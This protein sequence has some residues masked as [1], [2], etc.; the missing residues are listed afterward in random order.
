MSITTNS[1]NNKKLP[2]KVTYNKKLFCN[3]CKK[4]NHVE[5]NCF[6]KNPNLKWDKNKK[7]SSK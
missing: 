1:I 4:P 2:N 7:D 5:A 3:F 6:I